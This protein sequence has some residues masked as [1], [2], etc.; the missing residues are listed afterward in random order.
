MNKRDQQFNRMLRTLR[1]IAREYQ[2]PAQLH[3]GCGKDYGLEYAETL[4]MAYENIQQ[5]ARSAIKGVKEIKELAI[6]RQEG[7]E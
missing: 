6:T 7:G 4:E 5:E 1:R 3:R 2:T